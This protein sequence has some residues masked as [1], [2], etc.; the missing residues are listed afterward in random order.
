MTTAVW[1][2]LSKVYSRY[3][4]CSVWDTTTSDVGG[5]FVV[6]S[7][8]ETQFIFLDVIYKFWAVGINTRWF[9]YDRDK[10]WLVYTQ[11]VPVI[12]EPPCT[13]NSLCLYVQLNKQTVYMYCTNRC[14]VLNTY[15]AFKRL[16]VNHVKKITFCFTETGSSFLSLD[17]CCEKK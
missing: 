17:Y 7:V 14:T 8:K 12:F 10:L 6:I 3:K 5:I 11:I 4:I 9:K 16:G 15:V 13:I 1:Y 2:V